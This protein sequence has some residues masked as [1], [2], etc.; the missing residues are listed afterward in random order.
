MN[1]LTGITILF[2]VIAAFFVACKK[3]TSPYGTITEKPIA[4]AGLDQVITLPTDSISLD[5]SASHDRDGMITVWLWKKVSGPASFSMIDQDKSIVKVNNLI[6]GVYEFELKVGDNDGQSAEDIVRVYVV[7]STLPLPPIS[8]SCPNSNSRNLVNAQ[9]MPLHVL[10]IA[11][12]RMAI[13]SAGNKILFAG[14]A[15]SPSSTPSSR[16]DIYDIISNSWMTAELSQARAGMA[17]AVLG[18]KIFFAGGEISNYAFFSDEMD[19]YAYN[20]SSRVDI[21]DAVSNSWSIAELSQSRGG[22]ASGVAGDKVL[23]AGGYDHITITTAEIIFSD[24]VDIDEASSGLWS[25]SSLSQAKGRGLTATTVNNKVY[26]AGGTTRIAITNDYEGT[27]G[28]DIYDVNSNSW[29]TSSLGEAK[30]WHAAIAVNDKIYWAGGRTNTNSELYFKLSDIV[31]IRDINTQTTSFDCLFQP[32]SHFDAVLKNN[33][34]VFFTGRGG[35]KN[36]F[37]IYDITSNTWSI[38]VLPVNIYGASIISVNN[39][40]YVAG[41]YVNGILSNVVWKLEF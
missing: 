16:V 29:S 15:M 8:F 6:R 12:D 35:I 14:G 20:L 41:G 22:L 21:Y 33:K 28:I 31:D 17:V 32:N 5:G 38:G 19:S 1:R 25:T 37:D 26:F 9:L 27:A 34:I 13:A 36:K 40:I 4:Y 24:I 30:G 18:D 23:F 7:D 11:R 2:F 10:S 3:D 39:S